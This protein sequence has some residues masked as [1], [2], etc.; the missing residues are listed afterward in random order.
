MSALTFAGG[1][2]PAYHKD[3]TSGLAV[4]AIPAPQ[5]VIIPLS[6][7]IGAPAKACVE[8][9][10]A[11]KV[12]QMIAESG[13]FVSAP[14]HSSVSGTMK[15]IEPRP[16]PMGVPVLC[17]IIE[18]DG[19]DAAEDTA[20][21]ADW[22]T[23]SVAD[24]RQK[25]QSCG[26]V[27][28]GGAT[29]PTHVKLSPPPNKPIDTV[30]L[31][32]AECE[33]FLT[34]DHRIM[35]E[36]TAAMVEGLQII[37]RILDAKHAVV[38]IE[39]NKPDALDAVRS[40]CAS[41]D[42]RVV[43]LQIKYPQGGEK[44][45]ISAVLRREVPSGGLPMDVGVVVQ[46]AGTAR[47]VQQAVTAGRPLY[48]RILTVTGSAVPEPGNFLVR[49]GTPVATLLT[50]CGVSADRM[51]RLI[52][53]G[54]MMGFAQRHVDV[55]VTKGTSGILAFLETESAILPP[56]ACIRCGR[57]VRACPMRLVPS[58]IA[59]CCDHRLFS[60]ARAADAMDCMECGSCAHE[61]PS[62]IPLVQKIRLVKAEIL[63]ARRKTA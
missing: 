9:G 43:P 61:C 15:A 22:K 18:N 37:T 4:Q 39:V 3:R 12:G 23:A 60:H 62:R 40:A 41:T 21:T 5:E 51:G 57:C 42:I 24:L 27:G 56:M 25:I 13:G 32:G 53:G 33:P 31:N 7:H 44:Q 49:I 50:H 36:H 48:E 34:A 59:A 30:I 16:G 8:P 10:A 58:Q 26:V 14:V 55:P 20:G 17:A 6:Q 19:T 45:L 28:M 63:A 35:L 29:F 46:N 38:G 47:A 2:H 54:P 52:L 1:I 11:V